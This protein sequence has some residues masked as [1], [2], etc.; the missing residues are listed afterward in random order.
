MD[1]TR[2][3]FIFQREEG[4]DIKT[5]PDEFT[6]P[7][8]FRGDAF[9]CPNNLSLD[10]Y[11]GCP[12]NCIFCFCRELESTLFPAFYDDWKPTTYRPAD[13]RYIER[14]LKK[15]R[16]EANPRGKMMKALKGG[17]PIAL[18]SRSEPF[19]KGRKDTTMEVFKLLKDHG[20]NKVIINTKSAWNQI[21]PYIDILSELDVCFNISI[22]PG[23]DKLNKLLEPN[24]E[25]ATKRWG[26]IKLLSGQGLW[27]TARLEPL[28]ISI[29]D[30]NNLL[31]AGTNCLLYCILN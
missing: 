5:L 23:N 24:C 21:Q 4:K 30:D 19:L 11:C 15:A 2:D 27:A 6:K 7:L 28:L 17:L 31:N 18:G 9:V 16:T 13:V 22:L 3:S 26:T 29:N 10:P 12:R 8:F 1:K 25:P 20:Q 14:L